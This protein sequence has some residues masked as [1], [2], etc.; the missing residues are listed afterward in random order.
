MKAIGSLFAS[1]LGVSSKDNLSVYRMW[2]RL[3]EDALT[4]SHRAEIDAIFSRNV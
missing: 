3:R 1:M 2:D 4:P